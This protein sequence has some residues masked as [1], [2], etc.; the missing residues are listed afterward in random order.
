MM[1]DALL[2]ASDHTMRY[3]TRSSHGNPAEMELALCLQADSTALSACGRARLA[4][5]FASLLDL[6]GDPWHC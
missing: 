6:Q 1:P 2:A 3:I 5:L 4:S